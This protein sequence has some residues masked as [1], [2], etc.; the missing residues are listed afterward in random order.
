MALHSSNTRIHRPRRQDWTTERE[1]KTRKKKNKI[2]FEQNDNERQTNEN[3]RINDLTFNNN[4]KF[5]N[6]L[7]SQNDTRNREPY[8]R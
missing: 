7:S 8:A 5:R 3:D 6:N 1:N 2:S 4:H